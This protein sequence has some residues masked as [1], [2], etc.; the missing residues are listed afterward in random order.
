MKSERKIGVAPQT[1][2][3]EPLVG[4]RHRTGSEIRFAMPTPT[5]PFEP[6]P[7]S[8]VP[9]R[10]LT[11][12]LRAD[13][14]D[15]ISEPLFD[16]DNRVS[17]PSLGLIERDKARA[18]RAPSGVLR[19]VWQAPPIGGA[20]DRIPEDVAVVLEGWFS[21]VEPADVYAF[22]EVVH[23]N[24]EVATQPRFAAAINAVLERGVCDHR[25]VVRRLMPIASKSDIAAIER[26]LA[27]SRSM[28]WTSVEEASLA[29]LAALATK[30]EPDT[31]GAIQ[32]A[33]RAVQEAAH[34][35]TK[36]H[37][38]DFEDTLHGLEA[39][40]HIDR[41]LRA[42]YDGLFVYV[43]NTSRKTTTDDARLIVVMCA[44]FVSH[45]ASRS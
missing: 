41:T 45:L 10:S 8:R 27:A 12:E 25:F 31:R 36:E 34:A 39:K 44:G 30:P 3:A 38:F 16:D 2:E 5:V 24:L 9:R 1:L 11:E 28:M 22:I 15:V 40:G 21:L 32:K 43:S 14:W 20:G 13:L 42:A 6:L 19:R 33:T 29:A 37:Y 35:L 18:N 7:P 23:D 17:S 4:R 26:G